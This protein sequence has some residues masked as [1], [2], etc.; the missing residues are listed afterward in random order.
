MEFGSHR[1]NCMVDELMLRMWPS[2]VDPL[3]YLVH[4][5]RPGIADSLASSH[6]P[7]EGDDLDRLTCR[8]S[9]WTSKGVPS[10]SLQHQGNN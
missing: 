4:I 5:C 3:R 8:T 1:R 6:R 7:A 10:S 2:I 9:S